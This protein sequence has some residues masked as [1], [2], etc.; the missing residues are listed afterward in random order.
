MK[1]EYVEDK[2][3]C[4]PDDTV[5]VL[6]MIEVLFKD[7]GISYEMI[8]HQYNETL[9]SSELDRFSNFETRSYASTIKLLT[10]IV[11]ELGQSYVIPADVFGEM[12]H[13][14]FDIPDYDLGLTLLEL[15]YVTTL[16]DSGVKDIKLVNGEWIGKETVK[17]TIK[18]IGRQ[19]PRVTKEMLRPDI[20]IRACEIMH[21]EHH[22]D[23]PSV[24]W[25]KGE[26]GCYC[27]D[28]DLL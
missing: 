6:D 7:F 1:F 22:V 2:Q 5:R 14:S 18:K 11:E 3:E 27:K 26:T 20:L 10:N 8:V 16:I 19:K 15:I 24:K 12:C 23:C 17:G 9:A 4:I 28:S 13:M 21:Q 25:S